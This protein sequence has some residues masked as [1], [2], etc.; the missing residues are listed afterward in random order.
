MTWF[1]S[2]ALVAVYVNERFSDTARRAVVRAGQIPLTPL[3]ELEIRTTFEL[4][5]GRRLIS[6]AEREAVVADFE[7]DIRSHRLLPVQIDLDAV[8]DRA[9]ALSAAHAARTLSRSLD[10]LH[11]AGAVQQ[12]CRLFV[13]ADHRQLA[14]ARAVGLKVTDITRAR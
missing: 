12:G 3:H 2:S 13:S 6:K 8:F 9:R 4:L 7:T 10:L 11:V 5:V 14:V 1:D